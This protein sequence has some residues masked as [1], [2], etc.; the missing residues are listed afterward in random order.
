MRFTEEFRTAHPQIR[1]RLDELEQFFD[2]YGKRFRRRLIAQELR[3][4]RL[5]GNRGAHLLLTSLSRARAL[6]A[7]V[8]QCA[9][10]GLSDGMFLSARAH[11]E[12]TGL[13]AHFLQKL[14]KLYAGELS[15]EEFDRL[16][17]RLALGRRWQVPE[18]LQE[19]I[20]AINAITLVGSAATLF[21]GRVEGAERVEKHVKESYDFLSEF[22]HPNLLAR[23]TKVTMSMDLRITEYDPGFAISAKELRTCLIH[24]QASHGIFLFSY[25]ECF[26]LLAEHE[27]LPTLEA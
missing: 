20:T 11:W 12:M 26:R 19:D 23:S 1:P 13:V 14:R 7:A 15:Q 16:L 6:T 27:E 24:G 25:D 17:P 21:R 2:E 18:D 22:C 9:N 10:T 3:P 8:I 4:N 5:L